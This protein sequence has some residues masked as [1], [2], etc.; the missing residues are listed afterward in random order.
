MQ[1][2]SGSGQSYTLGRLLG[3][4]AKGDVYIVLGHPQLAAKLYRTPIS[5]GMQQ[6]LELMVKL[7]TPRLQKISAWPID[8][9]AE[10]AGGK[11][12]GFLMPNFAGFDPIHQLLGVKSRLEYFQNSSWPFLIHTAANT[13]RA[14]SVIH[15]H[16]HLI[17]DVSSTNMLVSGK[18]IVTLL[19]C[20]NYQ[21]TTPNEQ[22]LCE[23]GT[24]GYTPSELIGVDHTDLPRT[25]DHDH[26]GLAVIIF[27]LLFLGRHPFSGKFLG[28]G[29]KDL[30]EAIR[31]YRF[32]YGAD[33]GARQ[34]EPPPGTLP[35]EAMPAS[36]IS[37]FGRAFLSSE[38]RPKPHEWVEALDRL[39]KSLRKCERHSNHFYFNALGACP[40]C[41]IEKD[42]GVRLFNYILVG[43]GQYHTVFDEEEVWAQIVSVPPPG[44]PPV[45]L[46]KSEVEVTPAPDAQRIFRKRRIRSWVSI[47]A[48]ITATITV[49]I[50]G[51]PWWA[52]GLLLALI[53]LSGIVIVKGGLKVVTGDQAGV[54]LLA[55]DMKLIIER[56]AQ[57]EQ[58]AAQLEQRW[59]W[60]AGEKRFFEKLEDLRNKRTEYL[61]LPAL[62][63]RRLRELEKTSR[64]RQVERFLD[65]YLI[66]KSS[67]PD[68]GQS[69]K[70]ALLGYGIETAADV[71]REAVMR[72][73]GFEGMPAYK[74]LS[75]RR[76]IEE[77][78]VYNPAQDITQ[79]DKVT[80]DREINSIR[81]KL[82]QD[83][84]NG[85]T[86]L[87]RINREIATA[88][89]TLRDEV[90]ET[91]KRL[92]QAEED[93]RV[94]TT[95]NSPALVIASVMATAFLM[96]LVQAFLR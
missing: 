57:I 53:G 43:E 68:I 35:L 44:A 59:S 9:L 33:A 40:W 24:T 93:F 15:E 87:R 10:T 83:L 14:F 17:G 70:I 37:L 25:R 22:Y 55:P 71:K 79:I 69:Q 58:A 90:Q 74:L 54:D 7:N 75:W 81:M 28:D 94:A 66:A 67:I 26:F 16:G 2:F 49:L 51:L 29:E 61:S 95:P 38:A 42:S 20:D 6:R 47:P 96:L 84:G 19:D 86:H 92:A 11:V 30:D 5:A 76:S 63:Q 80:V 1:V 91:R 85:P 8:T 12:T 36:V 39:S 88:R 82:E 34:M 89:Q 41:E 73:P 64:E 48:V 27:Q 3:S 62:R 56:K 31:E 18:A 52:S 13:A 65:G 23:G 45:I 46:Q 60:E 50:L 78:F 21:I 32:A 4:G 72:V 77:K